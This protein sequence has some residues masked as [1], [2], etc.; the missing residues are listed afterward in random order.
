MAKKPTPPKPCA[1]DTM[2]TQGKSAYLSKHAPPP[3]NPAPMPAKCPTCG[4]TIPH[5]EQ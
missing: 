1:P 5:N 2:Q 4:K 3:A